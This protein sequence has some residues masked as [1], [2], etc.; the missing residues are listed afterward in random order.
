LEKGNGNPPV[1]R[2]GLQP[3]SSANAWDHPHQTGANDE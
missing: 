2:A 1:L 3:F